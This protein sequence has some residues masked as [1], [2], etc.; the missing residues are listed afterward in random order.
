MTISAMK[1]LIYYNKFV[2][3]EADSSWKKTDA[4]D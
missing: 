4:A 2:W 3:G 1:F